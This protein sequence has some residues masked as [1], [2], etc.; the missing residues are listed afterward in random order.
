VS[1]GRSA[2]EP[3]AG[4]L[5]AITFDYWNT[6]VR[7]DAGQLRG[8]RMDA[9]LGLLEE[10][11][12]PVERTALDQ[13]FDSSWQT[14][15][16]AWRANRQLL[17]PQAAATILAGLGHD[18]PGSLRAELIDAFV[19]A[20]RDAQLQLTDGIGDVLAALDDA[21]VRIGIICDVGMTG[22]LH[23]RHHL[24]R[25]GVLRHFDHWSFSD[26]VGWYKPARPIFEHALEGLGRPDP[27][28]TAHVGDLRA[29]DVAGARAMGLRSVR[30]AGVYDD[31]AAD[32]LPEADHVIASHHELLAL[33]GIH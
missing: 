10:A 32:G 16:E 9:W 15:N 2:T 8:L 27:A 24:E 22:S 33:A 29:T 4:D 23:L 25:H 7:D 26:E 18:L 5:G 20:G 21:G 13:L 30:Y 19:G 6:L 14:F 3:G 1:A 12:I 28:R 31:P 17:A 11:G